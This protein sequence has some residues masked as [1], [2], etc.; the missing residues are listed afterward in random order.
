MGGMTSNVRNGSARKNE[1]PELKEALARLRRNQRSP[2]RWRD[3]FAFECEEYQLQM[4][5]NTLRR[6]Y[7]NAPN[8]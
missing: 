3:E 7:L 4:R 5:V 2:D 6:R 1:P 8:C